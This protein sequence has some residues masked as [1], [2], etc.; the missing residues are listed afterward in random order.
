MTSLLIYKLPVEIVD[1]VKLYTGEGEWRNG[2]YVNIYRILKE[3]LRYAML[4]K[5]PKIRQLNLDLINKTKIGSVWF[6][7]PNNKFM[8]INKGVG[9]F[10][11]GYYY[12]NG[13]FCEMYYNQERTLQYIV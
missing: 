1:H 11:T 7:F 10:W 5:I 6:K 3:D 9:N 8:V 13:C 4:K 2:R 12:I